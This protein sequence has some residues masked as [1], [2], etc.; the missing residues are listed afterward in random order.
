MEWK[1]KK[2]SVD[3]EKIKAIFREYTFDSKQNEFS[4]KEPAVLNISHST[5]DAQI[6]TA[7]KKL[8]LGVWTHTH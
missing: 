7:H 3:A 6:I 4:V 2:R 8:S 5:L 1:E